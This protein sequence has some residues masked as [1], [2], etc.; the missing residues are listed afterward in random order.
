MDLRGMVEA[1][2]DKS[3]NYSPTKIWLL[4]K[5][6]GNPPQW[7]ELQLVHLVYFVWKG[8]WSEE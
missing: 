7:A 8:R 2:S 3:P 1:D 6:E 5:S 4:E